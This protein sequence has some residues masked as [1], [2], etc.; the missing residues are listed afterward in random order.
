MLEKFHTSA[1]P[2]LFTVYLLAVLNFLRKKIQAKLCCVNYVGQISPAKK[3]IVVTKRG[4]DAWSVWI[5]SRSNGEFDGVLDFVQILDLI[6]SRS[7]R[8]VLFISL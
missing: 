7:Q 3:V 8:I 6:N 2:C 1:R 5:L 4:T